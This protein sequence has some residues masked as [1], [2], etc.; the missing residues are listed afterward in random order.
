MSKPHFLIGHSKMG[1]PI[2]ALK[3][4]EGSKNALLIGGVHG[5]EPEGF[6]LVERFIR[7]ADWSQFESE[8]GLWVIP[9]LNP[10]GCK[11]NE[12]TNSSGVDLNRNM[13]TKDWSPAAKA[14]RY[15]PGPQPNSELETQ[16]LIE[17][18]H[19]IQP[20]GIVSAHSWEPVINYNGPA[21]K[22]AEHMALFNNY[23]ISDD[24]GYPTP[25]SLGTWAGWERNIP[26]ITLEIERGATPEKAW[27]TH[28]EALVQ[29]F[30]FL[31]K[32]Q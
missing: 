31:A 14:P 17:F 28:S 15:F 2:E 4:T 10:D 22:W 27:E 20:A 16:A 3:L 29:A 1:T 5:D 32:S 26:T 11:N 21:K 12:R 7:E 6:L 30:L 13:P 25:G 23:R 19:Q 8:I 9:R 24:I 18:I